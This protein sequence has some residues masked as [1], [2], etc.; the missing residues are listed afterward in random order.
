M[1]AVERLPMRESRWISLTPFP[2]R[3]GPSNI[4]LSKMIAGR[5]YLDGEDVTDDCFYADESKGE[6]QHYLRTEG[7]LHYDREADQIKMCPIRRGKVEI[8]LGGEKCQP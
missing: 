6:A 1:P 4:T 2:G 8:V 3:C 7:G 5:V